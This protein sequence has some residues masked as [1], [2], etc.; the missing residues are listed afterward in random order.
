MDKENVAYTYSEILFNLKKV[1]DFATSILW[2]PLEA[3]ML[4]EI[5]QL[6]KDNY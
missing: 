5:S 3:I 1:G 2:M 6:E 4:S